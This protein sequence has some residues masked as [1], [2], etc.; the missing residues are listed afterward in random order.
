[1]LPKKKI[2]SVFEMLS[3]SWPEAECEL[4]YKTPFQLLL[5]VVLSAQATDKS[6]N[7]VMRPF[8]ESHPGFSPSDLLEL[9][10]KGFFNLIKT[11]G[12]APTKSKNCFLLSK[13]LVERFDSQVPKNRE[14]LE[15]L[16]G[17]GRKTASV[18]LNVLHGEAVVAVDTHVA[19]LSNRIGL[20]P[21][22][23]ENR[24][25][26]EKQ[27]FEVIPKEFIT[28]AHHFLIF[29][30][31][32]HCLARKPKCKSCFLKTLCPKNQVETYE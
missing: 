28:R 22:K 23:T 15:S 6:V 16:N 5:A 20:L 19:R 1:M 13:K 9:G 11:I 30:G 29:H 21:K 10:E 8:L 27:L 7:K 14:D 24:D 3:L 17:V 31:R 25:M 2:Q 4:F 32:Y 26:I 18:V 12:L